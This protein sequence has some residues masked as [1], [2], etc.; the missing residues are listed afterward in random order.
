VTMFELEG[1]LWLVWVHMRER[2][3]D[4]NHPS[5]AYYGGRG[6][7]VAEPWLSDRHSFYEWS[8]KN[9]YSKG[10][11]LD[12]INNDGPYSPNNCRWVTRSENMKNT[13]RS[14]VITVNGESKNKSDWMLDPRVTIGY[15]TYYKRKAN[16]WTDED[17]LFTPPDARYQRQKVVH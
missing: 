7:S 17:A 6:I 12:R 13:R 2:C 15:G 5:Y 3:R 4:E 1:H 10:L 14:V 9:G 8:G 16:G 11:Q